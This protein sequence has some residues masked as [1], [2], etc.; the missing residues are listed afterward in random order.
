MAQ[1]ENTLGGRFILAPLL[2]QKF[3]YPV[4]ERCWLNVLDFALITNNSN[5]SNNFGALDRLHT[6]VHRPADLSWIT[7]RCPS[8]RPSSLEK[9][10]AEILR[11]IVSGLGITDQM[12]VALCSQRLWIHTVSA[13]R[14]HLSSRHKQ[15]SWAGTPIISLAAWLTSFPQ[16]LFEVVPELQCSRERLNPPGED[17]PWYRDWVIGEIASSERASSPE[18]HVVMMEFWRQISTSDIPEDLHSRM[19]SCLDLHALKDGAGCYL[20]NHTAKEYI[21]LELIKKKSGTIATL[22][23]HGW[24]NLAILLFWLIHYNGRQPNPVPD[25]SDEPETGDSPW[26]FTLDEAGNLEFKTD[27][28]KEEVRHFLRVGKW[29]AHC[30]DVT[31]EA[32]EE[33]IANWQ[34]RTPDVEKRARNWLMAIYAT[35]FHI[36]RDSQIGWWWDYWGIIVQEELKR[37][38]VRPGRS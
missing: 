17:S 9:L 27:L 24:L 1:A 32:P 34:D 29:A 3:R 14:E 26:D 38:E 37:G 22:V 36:R 20:R 21:R 18:Y 33:M 7:R 25:W 12:A 15:I 35:S 8:T 16:A 11:E 13:I 2:K 31:D 5:S 4:H 10:P 19:A 23:G 30:L 28:R 6:L